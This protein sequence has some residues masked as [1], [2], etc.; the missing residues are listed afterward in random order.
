MGLK[1]IRLESGEGLTATFVPEAGMIGISLTSSGEEMIGQRHGIES[2]IESGKTMGI[3]LLH[4]WANRLAS[5]RYEFD[6]TAVEIEA[7]AAGVRRDGNG[8]P[9][10]GNMAANPHWVVEDASTGEELEWAGLKATFDYGARPELMASFPFPHRITIEITL[11]GSALGVKTTVTATGE[12]AV[13]LAFGFH[14]Y[15]SLPGSDR[16]GWA[17]DLPEMTSLELD[18]RGIPTGVSHRFPATTETLESEAWDHAFSGVSPGSIFAV[19]DERRMVTVRFDEGFPATQVFAPPGE[20]VICFEPMKAPANALVSGEGLRSIAPGESDVSRFTITVSEVSETEPEPGSTPE[21]KFRLDPTR[22]VTEVRRV[23][24]D[25]V[26]TALGRLRNS[27]PENRSEA[28]HDARK[29]MKKMRAVLRLVRA[30]L[31][32]QTFRAENHRYRDAARLLSGA[33][34]ADVMVETIESLAGDYPAGATPLDGLLRE[35]RQRRD[36]E[37]SARG[38]EDERMAQA[39]KAIEEGGGLISSWSLG[40]SDWDLFEKGLRRTYRDG[41]RG[42]ALAETDPS[43]E[44]LHEWRKRVKDLWYQ[45]RLL[46]TAWNAPLK[47]LASETG[48]LGELL[49]GHNDLALLTTELANRPVGGPD[50]GALIDLAT[51]RKRELLEEAM[52]L[53]KRI[54]AEEPGSFGRR[55]GA[56]WAA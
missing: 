48:R 55:I 17:I 51:E 28:I 52:P 13:P 2:Y 45:L 18:D 14:P 19:A 15:I 49:G 54:Y 4:P 33:R 21:G 47:A 30:D 36:L 27:P 23:A 34:D 25:R 22:P 37:A 39:A 26:R 46:R 29:D 43:S 41:R 1:A 53:G 50:Y 12:V 44:N 42:M 5:D 20:N 16:G 24:R 3:P 35:L 11:A 9:I 10:H 32:K 8:L 7:D 31:G 38:D 6:E 56:Y 40:A